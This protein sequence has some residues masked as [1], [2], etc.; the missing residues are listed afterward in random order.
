[1]L[2]L[3]YCRLLLLLSELLCQTGS[4]M[5]AIPHLLDCLT[6]ARRH[7]L[8]YLAALAGVYLAYVQVRCMMCRCVTCAFD[9]VISTSHNTIQHPTDQMYVYVL[10]KHLKSTT[11]Y[12]W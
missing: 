12:L 8:E 2:L 1:M 10:M 5:V 6:Q 3:L 4:A 7:H 11:S 9:Q